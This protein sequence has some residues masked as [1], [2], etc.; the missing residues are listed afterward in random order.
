[1]KLLR[2]RLRNYRGVAE[3]ELHFGPLGVT[4]VDGPNEAGK[5][6]VAEALGVLF[7]HLDST[8]KSA[9]LELKPV[10]R[11]EGAEIEADIETGPYAFT[12]SKRFH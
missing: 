9:V 11:D 1:M 7:D 8:K 10:H 5:S 2:L 4:I 6:S 3:T 12:Y